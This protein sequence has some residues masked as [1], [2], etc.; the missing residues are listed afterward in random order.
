VSNIVRFDTTDYGVHF[1]SEVKVFDASPYYSERDAKRYSRSIQYAVHAA[2]TA[3]KNAGIEDSHSVD[4]TRAGVMIT[5]GIGGMDVYYET[6]V[7][8]GTRGPRRVSPFFI[9]MAIVNLVPGEVAIRMG[10]MGP[11][12]AP[13]SACA[14]SN[15]SIISAADQI[16]LGRAVLC[17]QVVLKKRYVRWVWVVLRL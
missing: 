15:H 4:V 5:S 9:P 12:W 13:V 7:A 1:G 17:L 16:R 6:S 3:L 2:E 10:W 8:L 14:S 11:N